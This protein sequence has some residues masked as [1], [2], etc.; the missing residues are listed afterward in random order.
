MQKRTEQKRLRTFINT[1]GQI[2]AEEVWEK[3]APDGTV[4]SRDREAAP[5][6]RSSAKVAPVRRRRQLPVAPV[7]SDGALDVFVELDRGVARRA[8]GS[9]RRSRGLSQS[10]SRYSVDTEGSERILTGHSQVSWADAS[11][12]QA[13]VPKL[14]QAH[15][16]GARP[17]T[18]SASRRSSKSAS[19]S[20][21]V[22]IF[23]NFALD[24]FAEPRRTKGRSVTRGG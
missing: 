3:L 7:M 22:S 1:Q 13:S 4:L 19:R 2:D 21:Q 23:G 14:S 15:A 11:L 5:A 16:S 10:G 12:H 24:A 8:A 17:Q 6:R 9:V 20:S 18:G